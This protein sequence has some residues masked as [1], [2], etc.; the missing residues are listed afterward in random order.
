[1]VAAAMSFVEKAGAEWAPFLA[2]APH[3]T[4]LRWHG[5]VARRMLIALRALPVHVLGV[6]DEPTWADGA[7]LPPREFFFHDLDHAR[8]K[9]RE[10]LLALGRAI[11][12]VTDETPVILPYARRH[13]EAV[14]AELWRRAPER[15][16][17]AR[18]LFERMDATEDRLLAQAKEWLLFEIVHEKSFPLERAILRRELS[19]DAHV[20][21]LEKKLESGFYDDARTDVFAR[22][23]EA[24]AALAEAL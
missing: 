21:K 18:L 11:P 19:H 1:M 6:V 9:V 16:A 23:E 4:G 14:S 12:D 5:P 7:V 3:V 20:R 24:R 13:V 22:L 15:W 10:D 17:L 2:L 8:Y